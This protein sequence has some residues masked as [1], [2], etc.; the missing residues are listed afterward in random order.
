MSFLDLVEEYP[1]DNYPMTQFEK[2]LVATLRAKDL[3]TGRAAQLLPSV[4]KHPY[5]SLEEIKEES[6]ALIYLEEEAETLPAE[7]DDS[8]T[9]EEE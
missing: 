2:V 7:T 6:I 1:R 9:E 5:M 4:H 8:G 3:H